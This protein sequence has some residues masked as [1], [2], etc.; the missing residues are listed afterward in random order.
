MWMIDAAVSVAVTVGLGILLMME[1]HQ[2][3]LDTITATLLLPIATTIVA[4][5]AGSE[6][7]SVLPN[8]EQA[9][10]T[11]I[12]CYIMWGMSVRTYTDE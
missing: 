4:A 11:I 8:P 10:G 7:A 1:S 2:R 3:S 12:T 9:L 5:S 6:V